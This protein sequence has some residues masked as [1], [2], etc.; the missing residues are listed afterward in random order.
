MLDEI[1]Q[2]AD[3]RMGK[4]IESFINDLTKVRTGRAHPSL[5]QHIMVPYYGA[6]TP[7]NQ[8]ANISVQDSRT[9]MVQPFEQSIGSAGSKFY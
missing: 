8:V 2:D 7:L 1:K 3:T 4:S 5:L 9:L 6:D